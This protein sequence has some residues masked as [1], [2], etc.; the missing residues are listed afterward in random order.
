ME[1]AGFYLRLDKSTFLTDEVPLLGHMVGV[2]GIRCQPKKLR[3]VLEAPPPEDRKSLHSF[4]GVAG[5]LRPFI[6]NYADY[7]APLQKHLTSVSKTAWSWPESINSSFEKL[8]EAVAKSISLGYPKPDGKFTIETDASDYGA[9]ALL[10]QLQNNIEVPLECASLKFNDTQCRWDTRE[11]ELYAIIWAVERWRHYVALTHFTV[12]TDHNNLRYLANVDRGKVFRWAR[13]LAQYNLTIEFKSGEIN[14]A[15]DWLSRHAAMDDFDDKLIDYISLPVYSTVT[16]TQRGK[17]LSVPDRPSREAFLRAYASSPSTE[18]AKFAI[19][20]GDLWVHPTNRRIYVPENLRDRLL[21]SN[22][23]GI[24]GHLGVQRTLRRLRALYYWPKMAV[25]TL[26][27][28]SS[29]IIC[30]RL[31]RLPGEYTR[32]PLGT[33]NEPCALELVSLDHVI[34][35]MNSVSKYMLVMVDHATRFLV[36]RWV[37]D[38][39]AETTLY[40]WLRAWVPYFGTPRA[41]LTDNGGGFLAKFHDSVIKM[42]CVHLR[43][44][45]YHPQGNSINEASHKGIKSILASLW[46]EGHDDIDSSLQ[47]AVRLHN[48]TPHPALKTS[49]YETLFGKPPLNPYEQSLSVSPTEAQRV[50]QLAAQRQDRWRRAL[51]E[52]RP[53]ESSPPPELKPG[54]VVV[55]RLHPNAA[56]SRCQDERD[57]RWLSPDWTLPLTVVSATRTQAVL[58]PYGD[59]L[60][61]PLTVHRSDLRLFEKPTWPLL[62]DLCEV[63]IASKC[64]SLPEFQTPVAP[65]STVV[66]PQPPAAKKRRIPPWLVR[67]P[68]DGPQ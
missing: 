26:N 43:S 18:L 24:G 63:Y 21:T 44:A 64:P 1:L 6:P 31:K 46:Q 58:H 45:P 10:L 11:R 38:M 51:L 41:V 32:D 35:N 22:H 61:K 9:G 30:K 54:D 5:Y 50:A 39:T 16:H 40:S 66:A 48:T 28:I 15:A 29:C 68:T 8:K 42:G 49:P 14:Y 57:T 23:F 25:D 33:L 7:A 59:A 4:L 17:P 47:L 67:P 19:P 20:E 36:A 34:I 53:L 62:R 56:T 12:R 13:F 2:N 3:S 65:S 27:Y 55:A 60:A 52:H 37:G